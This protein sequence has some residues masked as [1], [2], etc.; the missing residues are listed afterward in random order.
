MRSTNDFKGTEQIIMNTMEEEE[1]MKGLTDGS[2]IIWTNNAQQK[3]Q[4]TS[5]EIGR[6]SC[7]ERV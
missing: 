3:C 5:A 7:R 6:A 1:S 2:S 4:I